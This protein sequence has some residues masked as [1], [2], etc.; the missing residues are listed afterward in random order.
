MC[1]SVHSEF[2]GQGRYGQGRL[3]L[4][5]AVRRPSSGYSNVSYPDNVT[6]V[7]VYAAQ[8]DSTTAIKQTFTVSKESSERNFAGVNFTVGA[9]A[10]KWSIDLTSNSSVGKSA[11]SLT[12]KLS[13]AVPTTT[14]TSKRAAATSSP[15]ITKQTNSPST[16]MTTY[17]LPLTSETSAAGTTTTSTAVVV[18]F[19]VAL[20]DGTLT[21]ISHNIVASSN[22][23]ASLADYDLSLTFPSFQT[24][25]VYDPNLALGTY[26]TQSSSTGGGSGDDVGLIVGLAVG[27]PLGLL[28]L[29]VLAAIIVVAV[30]FLLKHKGTRHGR[31]TTSFAFD[32]L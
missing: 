4:L 28:A 13:A 16:N 29:A 18:V 2:P 19:D 11:F 27:I 23:S 30:V 6:S 5:L 17:T 14:T 24:E 9:G 12:Y 7:A 8:L 31:M 22:A 3:T 20:V 26:T 25:L 1:V 15:V 32:D 21:P 10:V